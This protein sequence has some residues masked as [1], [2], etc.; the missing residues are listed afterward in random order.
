M[1]IGEPQCVGAK[2]YVVCASGEF[3]GLPLFPT[4]LLSRTIFMTATAFFK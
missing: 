1:H 4:C 2:A 3:A